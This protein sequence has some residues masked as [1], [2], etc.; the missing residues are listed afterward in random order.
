MATNRSKDAVV[1]VTEALNNEDLAKKFGFRF[2]TGD[3][4]PP[5]PKSKESNTERWNA[6]KVWLT[7]DER[8]HNEWVMIK[9]FDTAGGAAA[10]ASRIN[11]D[12]EKSFPKAEGWEARSDTTVK[13]DGDNPGKSELFIRYVPANNT[14]AAK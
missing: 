3:D 9:E 11:N 2:V 7:K 5:P 1:S 13:K 10:K 6:V 12:Y 4:V 14:V 8:A